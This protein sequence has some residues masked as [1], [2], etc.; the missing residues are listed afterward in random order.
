MHSG[1]GTPVACILR[2][3]GV[4]GLRPPKGFGPQAGLQRSIRRS[5][6]KTH[7]NALG[8]DDGLNC[9]NAETIGRPLGSPA[10]LDRLESRLGRAVRPAVLAPQGMSARRVIAHHIDKYIIIPKSARS[11]RVRIKVIQIGVASGE[12]ELPRL[13]PVYFSFSPEALDFVTRTEAFS[14]IR[15][16]R[17][18]FPVQA[19]LFL[20]EGLSEKNAEIEDDIEAAQSLGPRC[21]HLVECLDDSLISQVGERVVIIGKPGRHARESGIVDWH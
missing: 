21:L 1:C 13:Q 17:D 9:G 14:V 3:T 8:R 19:R 11:R 18:V 10:F 4:P 20:D 12:D 5:A 7:A 6:S 2:K 15:N 16:P